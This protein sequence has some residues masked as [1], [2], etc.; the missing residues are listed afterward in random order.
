MATFVKVLSLI[1]G[2]IALIEVL[3]WLGHW[4]QYQECLKKNHGDSKCLIDFLMLSPPIQ[5]VQDL[6]QA[7]D[8]SD[9]KCFT[10]LGQAAI[11][12]KIEEH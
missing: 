12:N 3:V 9:V 8:K 7:C 6:K 5:D 10:K 11:E 2:L 1:L 4:S